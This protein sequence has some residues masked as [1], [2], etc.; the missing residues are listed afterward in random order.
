[1]ENANGSRMIQGKSRIFQ[2]MGNAAFSLATLL[3]APYN[4][5]K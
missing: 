2:P 1:M 5:G 4:E 3:A